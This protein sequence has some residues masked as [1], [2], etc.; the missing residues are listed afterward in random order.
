M[1]KVNEMKTR[2]EFK[3]EKGDAYITVD[4]Q[5]FRITQVWAR[6]RSE[7]ACYVPY[8]KVHFKCRQH[9]YLYDGLIICKTCDELVDYRKN[10]LDTW[11]AEYG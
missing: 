2:L 3:M 10:D 9:L 5:N 11:R 6:D 4:R 8:A 1:E 7:P